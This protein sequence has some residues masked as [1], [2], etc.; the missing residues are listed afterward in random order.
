MQLLESS[1]DR[2]VTVA[3]DHGLAFGAPD[4]FRDTQETLDAVLEAGPDAV[5][6]S[7]PFLRHHR[8]SIESAGVQTVLASDVIT[9]STIPGRMDG[10]DVWTQAFPVEELIEEDPAAVKVVLVFG[11]EDCGLFADNIEA[12]PRLRRRLSDA[13][14][15]LV[16]EPVLWGSRVTEQQELDPE[17]VHSATRMAWEYGADILKTPYTG[18]PET[19]RPIV[20]TSPVPVVV[21]GGPASVSAEDTVRDV[22]AAREAGASGVFMGRKLWQRDDPT[23][24]IRAVREVVHGGLDADEAVNYLE[25]WR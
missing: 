3:L 9:F 2:T 13:G 6:V 14:I 25:E 23:A 18:D 7:P 10:D 12:I 24:T 1:A 11:R 22:V 21:L 5:A 8:D 17:L 16:V 19:F 20:E 4:G 15:Q